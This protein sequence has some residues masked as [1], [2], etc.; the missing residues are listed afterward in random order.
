MVA[1]GFLACLAHLT[2]LGIREG[3]D[4]GFG[5][6]I[7][8]WMMLT[9]IIGA[10]IAYVMANASYY[11]NDPIAIIRVDQGGL[12]YYGGFIG[13]FIAGIVFAK[14]KKLSILALADFVVSAL[15][16]GHFFGRLGCFLNACCYG[17]AA[18]LPWSVFQQGAERH[19]VQLYEAFLNLA[20][21]LLLIPAYRRRKRNGEVLAIY[22]IIYPLGRFMLE[23]LRGDERLGW[24]GIAYAQIISLGLVLVGLILGL[25]LYASRPKHVS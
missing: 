12:I 17:A 15:P 18:S 7:A 13:A 10:R 14:V 22:L 5:S 21:Y 20:V 25:V 24:H 11:L 3:R 2:I 9:G 6:D 16:L 23:F 4:P 19:P 1:A 8:F